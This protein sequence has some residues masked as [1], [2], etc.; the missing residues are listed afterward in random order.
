[1]RSLDNKVLSS[2]DSLFSFIH[3][4]KLSI[5]ASLG[6][7]LS[8]FSRLI[9]V[10]ELAPAKLP[11]FIREFVEHTLGP[12]FLQ[13]HP[14]HPEKAF[15]HSSPSNPVFLIAILAG[16]KE[17]LEKTKIKV[18]VPSELQ[19]LEMDLTESRTHGE[20]ILVKD[21]EN[22]NLF[23]SGIEALVAKRRSGSIHP[24]FRLILSGRTDVKVSA[25]FVR[26]CVKMPLEGAKVPRISSCI[27]CHFSSPNISLAK[28]RV[29]LQCQLFFSM[30]SSSKDRNSEELGSDQGTSSTKAISASPV[31]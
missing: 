1:M 24:D 23:A 21:I 28:W 19:T 6:E 22:S 11:A 29:G 5:P 4:S 15:E 12:D 26:K 7:H 9:L 20:W 2:P 31:M 14:S 30:L 25:T 8:E 16:V 18:I 10:K 3:G 13:S 17:H 27:S